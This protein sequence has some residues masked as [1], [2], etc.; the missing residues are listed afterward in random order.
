MA[1]SLDDRAC[2]THRP[3]KKSRTVAARKTTMAAR[4]RRSRVDNASPKERAQAE[5]LVKKL[6][7]TP[8]VR[9]ELIQR[10]KKQIAEGTYETPERMEK[11]VEGMLREL[12]EEGEG[13]IFLE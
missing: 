5:K 10:I 3:V 13:G 7:E 6:Q 9:E 8:E 4:K 11:A 12:F 2:K 1:Y